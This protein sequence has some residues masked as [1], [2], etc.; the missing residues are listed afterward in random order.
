MCR[1]SGEEPNPATRRSRNGKAGESLRVSRL[2]LGKGARGYDFEIDREVLAKLRRLNI[3]PSGLSSD[4]EFLRRVTIDT[5]GSLPT[6]DQVRAFL[7]DHR[8]DKR[9]RKID[10]LLAHPRHA[11]LWASKFCDIT[12]C[13]VDTMDGPPEVRPKLAQ[14]WHDWF[15]V[16]LAANVPYDKIARGVL[17]ATSREERGHSGLDQTRRRAG[18]LRPRRLRQPVRRPADARPVLAA[19]RK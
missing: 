7:A 18:P 3:E 11:A 1:R 15:R 13:N 6:P 12:G 5:I 2:P 19:D 17:L 4:E 8:P 14:M 16:R 10:E 9:S